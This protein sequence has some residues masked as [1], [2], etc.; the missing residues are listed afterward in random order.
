MRLGQIAAADPELFDLANRF[1]A[2]FAISSPLKNYLE[3]LSIELIKREKKHS[4]VV[5]NLGSQAQC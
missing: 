3:H 1:L 4:A 2:I 5:E